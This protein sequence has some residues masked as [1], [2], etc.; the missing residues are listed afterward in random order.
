MVT[1]STFTTSQIFLHHATNRMSH[2]ATVTVLPDGELLA[3]W[4]TGSYETSPDQYIALARRPPTASA[5]TSPERI[6][7]THGHAAGQPVFLLDHGG[8]LWL[9]FVT[10]AGRGWTSAQL[11]RQRSDDLGRHWSAP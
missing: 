1:M 8:V 5:W 11:M 4:M 2:C 9:Y 6:V 10:L 3:A 7:D